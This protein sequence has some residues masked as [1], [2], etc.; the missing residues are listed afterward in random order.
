QMTD[1]ALEK[2]MLAFI[3][4][5]AD[6]LVSTT[7]I[8]SGM[9]IPSANTMFV[10]DA[11][12]FGLAQLHQLRGRVGRSRHRAYCY[13]LLPEERR[14]TEDALRRL[15]AIEDYSMLGAGFRIAMRDLEIRGAGNLLGAEQSGHIASVGY[16]MYCRMLEDA[17]RD[18]KQD[19]RVVAGDTTIDIGLEGSIPKGYIPNDQ[20]RMEAYRKIGEADRLESLDAV[21]SDLQNAY[22]EIPTATRRHVEVA[23]IRLASAL[24]GVKSLFVKD[25]DVIF[26]TTAPGELQAALDGVQG[27]VRMIAPDGAGGTVDAAEGAEVEVYFRP[28]ASFLEPGSLATVLRRRLRGRLERSREVASSDE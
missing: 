26:R 4:R 18:I 17:V 25:R 14:M 23:E 5:E 8:E 24:L 19:R 7:I 22:G 11:N 28:P 3:R 16:D 6:I 27:S 1:G 10:H 12:R 13:L 15:K 9:D 20:R 21:V 2:V